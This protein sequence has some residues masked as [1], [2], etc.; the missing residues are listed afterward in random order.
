MSKDD[1]T[2]RVR[3]KRRTVFVAAMNA[4]VNIKTIVQSNV[5]PKFCDLRE[6]KEK[7]TI[8]S[9]DLSVCMYVC[10]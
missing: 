1:W 4:N 3:K 2:N 7:K 6:E 8:M 5:K 9:V 10:V